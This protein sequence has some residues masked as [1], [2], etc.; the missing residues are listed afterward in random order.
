M[1]LTPL[2]DP[3]QL[4]ASSF[5]L[6]S[7]ATTVGYGG[8]VTI[9][10][11]L[12]IT[13]TTSAAFSLYEQPAGGAKTLINSAGNGWTITTAPKLTRNTTFTAV[14]TGNVWWSTK[15]DTV[16]HSLTVGVGVK[17]SAALSGYYKTTTISGGS[18][19]VYHHGPR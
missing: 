4:L 13:D 7:S 11:S 15:T 3:F 10:A 18:Y 2:T 9:T 16:T 17:L 1:S 12:G 19:R 6:A 5:K 14:F 8:K